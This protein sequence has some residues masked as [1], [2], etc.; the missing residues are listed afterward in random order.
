MI[1][2]PKKL[3]EF[4]LHNLP[5]DMCQELF[6]VFSIEKINDLD[7]RESIMLWRSLLHLY[8]PYLVV[9]ESNNT[10]E[11]LMNAFV[12]ERKQSQT[13]LREMRG[14]VESID[15]NLMMGALSGNIKQI[16]E[17]DLKP[18][19]KQALYGLA[20]A[21]EHYKAIFKLDS[22]A[23]KNTLSFIA[24]IRG[25]KALLNVM[26]NVGNII[27][28]KI[29]K[30]WIF[31]LASEKEYI[32]VMLWFNTNYDI[33]KKE[34]LK[35]FI[36]FS[37]RGHLEWVSLI[38]EKCN[39]IPISQLEAAILG[40]LQNGHI[41][42]VDLIMDNVQGINID[43][44]AVQALED[45]AENEDLAAAK[46]IMIVFDNMDKKHLL[47]VLKQAIKKGHFKAFRYIIENTESLDLEVEGAGLLYSAARH[48][49]SEI[50]KYLQMVSPA[51]AGKA[52]WKASFFG[53]LESVEFIL[54]ACPTISVEEKQK[55]QRANKNPI[56]SASYNLFKDVLQESIERQKT[57]LVNYERSFLQYYENAWRHA[58]LNVQEDYDPTMNKLAQNQ[59][60][61]ILS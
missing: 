13:L 28:Q 11:G 20:F 31:Q 15:T 58:G 45:A 38:L 25:H 7:E 9:D 50:V 60:G 17:S 10:A 23:L 44:L 39:T 41:A 43:S 26:E 35:T 32:D 47:T 49:N 12:K 19:S 14:V 18:S 48:Q 2:S 54:E 51:S 27:C 40:A 8:F 57:H 1:E 37:T 24:D 55:A 4:L 6:R 5:K 53:S 34:L 42:V 36:Q 21:N 16:E 33:A 52:L 56:G 30:R 3:P 46:N 22:K 29:D 59:R 61:C